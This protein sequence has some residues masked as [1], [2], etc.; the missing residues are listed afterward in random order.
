MTAQD[1][2]NLSAKDLQVLASGMNLQPEEYTDALVLLNGIIDSWDAQK[3]R[4]F[5][6][7]RN[8]YNLANGVGSYTL[9]QGG[10]LTA[11]RPIAIRAATIIDNGHYT[12][13]KIVSA[14]EFASIS[15]RGDT[16]ITPKVLWSDDGFP[17][18]TIYVYPLPSGTPQLELYTWEPLVQLALISTTFSMPPGYQRALQKALAVEMAPMFGRQVDPNTLLAVKAEAFAAISAL[19]LPPSPG[20]AQEAAARAQVVAM[21]TPPATNEGGPTQ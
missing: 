4:I 14:E 7:D 13:M 15:T 1:L 21:S 19:N 17:M 18:T 11:N 10:G 3:L 2:I 8:A 5:A 16:S 6:I 12:P 9:G 20:L